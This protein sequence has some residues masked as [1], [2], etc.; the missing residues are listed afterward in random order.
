MIDL[1]TFFHVRNDVFFAYE[2]I[3]QNRL[4]IYILLSKTNDE[5]GI[6]LKWVTH[7]NSQSI[8]RW[9]IGFEN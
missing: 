5:V 7:V 4:L 2:L 1:S 3:K 6:F 8:F 9:E